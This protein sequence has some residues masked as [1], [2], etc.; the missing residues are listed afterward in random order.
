MGSRRRGMS[1]MSSMSWKVLHKPSDSFRTR[2]RSLDRTCCLAA[3]ASTSAASEAGDDDVEDSDDSVD[4]GLEGGTDGVD[5]SHQGR[6]DG[7]EHRG[8]LASGLVTVMDGICKGLYK[9][10]ARYNG[11]HCV[12]MFECVFCMCDLSGEMCTEWAKEVGFVVVFIVLRR[13]RGMW[14]KVGDGCCETAKQ[15]EHLYLHHWCDGSKTHDITHH[16]FLS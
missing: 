10:Y 5:D 9:T 11:T 2:S 4:D 14:E 6:A 13:T 3:S 7:A 15:Q 1:S 12:V 16:F 8:D